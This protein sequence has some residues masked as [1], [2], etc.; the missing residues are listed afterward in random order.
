MYRVMWTDWLVFNPI[1]FPCGNEEK[2]D[3]CAFAFL[4]ARSAFARAGA[5]C[6]WL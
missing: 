6:C 5:N 1:C 3:L 4:D 2:L